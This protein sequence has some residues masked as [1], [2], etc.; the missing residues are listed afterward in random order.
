M[1]L[2]II[3]TRCLRESGR[4]RGDRQKRQRA[5]TIAEQ[6]G[7]HFRMSHAGNHS[8]IS[9]DAPLYRPEK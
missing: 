4:H 2:Y 8:V 1:V 7:L 9:L 3:Q 5:E 6:N